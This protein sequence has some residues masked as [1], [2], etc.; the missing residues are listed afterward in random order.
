M[1]MMKK[2]TDFNS[3]LIYLMLRIMIYTGKGGTG[4]TVNACST[5]VKLA[6][7]N[8]KTLIISSDPAHTLSDAFM[9]EYSGDELK[10]V[11]GRLCVL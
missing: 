4:K 9:V 2:V 8:Q 3:F 6:D 1:P 11:G 7:N 5:A 10:E